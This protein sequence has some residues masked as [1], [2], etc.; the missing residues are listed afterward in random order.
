MIKLLSL[1]KEIIREGGNVFT[2][3]D[4]KTADIVQGNI[5]KTVEEFAKSMSKIFQKKISR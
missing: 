2:D 5:K 4:S 1:F 3:K